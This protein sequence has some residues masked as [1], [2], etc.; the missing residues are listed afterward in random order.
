MKWMKI[1]L[2]VLRLCQK[3]LSALLGSYWDNVYYQE[4]I[5]SCMDPVFFKKHKT[6]KIN[7]YFAKWGVRVSMLENDYY[8]MSTGVKSDL[9]VPYVVWKVMI[10]SFLNR[11]AWRFAYADK[12]VFSRLLNFQSRNS[13][14]G[15]AMPESVFSCSNGFFFEEGLVPST[16]ER[17]V[18]FL[19]NAREDFIIKPSVESHGGHGVAKFSA[20]T[21]DRKKL[22][23]L[24]DGYGL[25]FVIQRMLKQHPDIAA[26]NE[27]S[28][29]TIRVVTYCDF[30]GCIK[31]L[32][33]LQRFGIKGEVVDNASSGGCFCGILKDGT[34]QRIG[35]RYGHMETF[36][37]PSAVPEKAPCFEKIKEITCSL[38]RL[39]SPFKMVA[40][41]I[42]VDPNEIVNVVEYNLSPGHELCQQS[43]GPVFE[44]KDLDEIME[45]VSKAKQGIVIRHVVSHPER[46]GNDF[47]F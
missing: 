23:A 14:K 39:L 1:R 3:I 17:C 5:E 43:L 32:Y 2:K 38:H 9:Y 42:S 34:Y 30:E 37:I 24:I 27:S 12:N 10:Y 29:N 20:G 46:K 19:L 16:K 47:Y 11:D 40:W 21:L 25:D 6:K 8:E 4:H 28:I 18:D 31:V 45:H 7:P 15:F 13:T 35:H 44:K 33:A 36:D 41:D 26:F 22:M